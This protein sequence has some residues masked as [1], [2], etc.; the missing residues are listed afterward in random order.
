MT[1]VWSR[2]NKRPE[3]APPA[4]G[5]EPAPRRDWVTLPPLQRTTAPLSTT[6]GTSSFE[7]SLVS[8]QIRPFLEPLSHYLSLAGPGGTV[9]G[10]LSPT[11]GLQRFTE[12]D[13]S[14]VELAAVRTF[15]APRPWP[16]AQPVVPRQAAPPRPLTP[17][18]APGPSLHFPPG[19]LPSSPPPAP[20][21]P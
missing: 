7:A 20:A 10:L 2:R 17:A 14:P 18:P 21:A 5:R 1:P 12:P 3:T 15:D 6:F 11:I 13:P 8:R 19:P 9:R 16:A 4:V